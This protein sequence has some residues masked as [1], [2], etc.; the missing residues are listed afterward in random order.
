MCRYSPGSLADEIGNG[1]Q[2][3]IIPRGIGDL[4]ESARWCVDIVP[5]EECLSESPPEGA[6]Y[7]PL[8]TGVARFDSTFVSTTATACFDIVVTRLVIGI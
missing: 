4:A 5:D 3:A 7:R 8:T 6:F 2:T 1:S